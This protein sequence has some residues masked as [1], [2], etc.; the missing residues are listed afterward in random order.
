MDSEEDCAQPGV[1]SGRIA[2]HP[3][4][5]LELG[6]NEEFFGPFMAQFLS[7]TGHT[8]SMQ[9][10][11]R[12]MHM[13]YTKGWSMLKAAER[14]LGFP[15][16]VTRSG[17]AEGGFSQLT[18]KASEFLNRYL[19]MEQALRREGERLFGEY[20]PEYGGDEPAQ[21]ADREPEGGEMGPG[22]AGKEPEGGERRPGGAGKEP[23]DGERRPGGGAAGQKERKDRG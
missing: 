11:C 20:F 15:I 4:I 12:Q 17:G 18:P 23:E 19:A 21:S 10:A 6:R 3:Q 16:L 9:T 13:S 22:G 1:E 2:V 7:I 5:S 8:G 14:Q